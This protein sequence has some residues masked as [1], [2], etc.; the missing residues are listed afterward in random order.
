[1]PP[2]KRST[3]PRQMWKRCYHR[4]RYARHYH[5]PTDPDCSWTRTQVEIA[6]EVLQRLIA[7]RRP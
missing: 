1:M 2:S 4:F 7:R 5:D 6:A 3:T